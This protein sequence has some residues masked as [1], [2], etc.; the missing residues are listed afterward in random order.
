MWVTHQGKG[1]KHR[2]VQAD[3]LIAG[4]RKGN[5][6]GGLCVWEQWSRKVMVWEFESGETIRSVGRQAELFKSSSLELVTTYGSYEAGSGAI[7]LNMGLAGTSY[8]MQSCAWTLLEGL[9]ASRGQCRV[10][11]LLPLGNIDGRTPQW[12][13]GGW[14]SADDR[15]T[16]DR[17][18][19][20]IF[21]NRR[22]FRW[23]LAGIADNRR[24]FGC[25]DWGPTGMASVGM[26][27]NRRESLKTTEQNGRL[28]MV[29]T[30]MTT[31]YDCNLFNRLVCVCKAQDKSTQTGQE[32]NTSVSHCSVSSVETG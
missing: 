19:A 21:D 25:R 9:V 3:A 28:G 5:L 24:T 10:K 2:L 20:G 18:L 12:S 27:N 31:T 6:A 17:E 32:I 14:V 26:V 16:W 8:S 13:T 4:C 1:P 7:V 22:T 23:E 11:D 15:K 30:E 29:V